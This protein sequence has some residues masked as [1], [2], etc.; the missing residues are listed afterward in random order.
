MTSA[1]RSPPVTSAISPKKSPGPSVATLRRLPAAARDAHLRRARLDQKQRVAHVALAH[2]HVARLVL[3]A[4]HER[5]EDGRLGHR[6]IVK[7]VGRAQLLAGVEQ[8]PTRFHRHAALRQVGVGQRRQTLRAP[9][10]SSA[11]RGCLFLSAISA[12]SACLPGSASAC[13]TASRR[14]S[15][16]VEMSE[17]RIENG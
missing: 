13:S 12:T 4:L 3:A 6:Q 11:A 9:R 5:A 7:Q 2:D 16:A 8:L 14:A 10:A 15:V 1:L 17:A